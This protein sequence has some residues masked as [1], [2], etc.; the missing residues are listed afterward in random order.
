[1]VDR[2]P[3]IGAGQVNGAQGAPA[4]SRATGVAGDLFARELAAAA[5]APPVDGPP[6]EVMGA[7]DRA[8]EVLGDLDR[9]GISLRLTVDEATN[10]VRIQ[11]H[12]GS[13]APMRELSAVRALDALVGAG[14]DAL[15]AEA[16]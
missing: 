15:L 8:A 11:V 7:L 3:G 13:G 5:Q 2:T 14:A 9:R 12:D 1:M 10:R 6:P 16:R 4:T